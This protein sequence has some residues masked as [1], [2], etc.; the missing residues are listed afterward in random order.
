MV[1]LKPIRFTKIKENQEKPHLRVIPD[2][3]QK[4]IGLYKKNH[5]EYPCPPKSRKNRKSCS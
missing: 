5:V 2:R 3:L 1:K 4:L